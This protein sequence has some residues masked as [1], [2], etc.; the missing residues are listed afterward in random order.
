MSLVMNSNPLF[1]IDRNLR[2]YHLEKS[3]VWAVWNHIRSYSKFISS[4]NTSSSKLAK[5]GWLVSMFKNMRQG[6]KNEKSILQRLPKV[7]KKWSR[8]MLFTSLSERAFLVTVGSLDALFK[9]LW[10]GDKNKDKMSIR[11]VK[12]WTVRS[13]RLHR[14]SLSISS[15]AYSTK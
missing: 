14:T 11:Q 5:L 10:S 3:F 4:S 2:V 12:L 15:G 7:R 9:N 1:Y 6:H 8:T 13:S